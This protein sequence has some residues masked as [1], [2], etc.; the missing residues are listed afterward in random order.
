MDADGAASSRVNS[1]VLRLFLS[2]AQY[3]AAEISWKSFSVCFVR[4]SELVCIMSL[5]GTASTP[6]PKNHSVKHNQSGSCDSLLLWATDFWISSL[7]IINNPDRERGEEK[8][9]T[10][11]CQT[12]RVYRDSFGCFQQRRLGSVLIQTFWRFILWIFVVSGGINCGKMGWRG[13]FGSAEEQQRGREVR[14]RKHT[15]VKKPREVEDTEMKL[16]PGPDRLWRRV[17]DISQIRMDHKPLDAI[18]F[19]GA[20]IR[21]LIM[22]HPLIHPPPMPM[23]PQL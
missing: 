15:L 6:P 7:E 23:S 14:W 16:W 18:Q 8:N 12:R 9:N 11:G 1:A 10:M 13:D 3:M 5:R 20:A 21:R 17:G 2:L 22:C 19:C 4:N